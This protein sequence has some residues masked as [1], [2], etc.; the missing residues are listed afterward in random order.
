MIVFSGKLIAYLLALTTVI[1]WLYYAFTLKRTLKD[2]STDKKAYFPRTFSQDEF[3]CSLYLFSVVC[4]IACVNFS[5]LLTDSTT[6]QNTNE[7]DLVSYA[8]LQLGFTVVVTGGLI[9]LLFLPPSYHLLCAV[10]PG[11]L[12][13]MDAAKNMSLL[14]LKKIFVCYV[15]HEIRFKA[16]FILKYLNY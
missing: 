6:W 9:S 2:Y 14:A 8:F 1:S 4:Y 7:A 11:R 10:L 13:Q 15:S 16:F 5:D 3:T 12:A